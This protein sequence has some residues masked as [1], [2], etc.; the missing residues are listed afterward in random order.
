MTGVEAAGFVLGV[1]PLM[2]SAAEHYEDVFRPFNRYRKFAPELELYQQ[3]L[4]TQKTIFRNECH[5]LLATLTNRQTAKEMLREGKHPSWE[6][7]DL[8]ERF[9][10]Q[11]G[12]SGVACKNIIDLMRGKL[13]EIEEKTESFGL[14]L[15]H[16]FPVRLRTPQID[17]SKVTHETNM[18]SQLSS[19]RDKAWRSRIGKKLKFSLSESQLEKTLEDL[20]TLNQDFRTLAAQTNKLDDARQLPISSPNSPPRTDEA[21]KDCRLVRTAS[22]QLHQAL[23]RACKIHEKHIAHFRLESQHVT[24]EQPGLPIVRFNMAFTHCSSEAP[25]NL[26]PVWIAVDSTFDEGSPA[27]PQKTKSKSQQEAQNC[28]RELSGTLKREN[29]TSC[30]SPVKRIKARTVRFDTTASSNARSGMT[31]TTTSVRSAPISRHSHAERLLMQ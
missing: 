29:S 30:P 3:Q 10:K 14:V 15:Q 31:M 8:D 28:L 20:R 19:I 16:S 23:E 18:A 4:G 26:E 5:L 2:I 12:D 17:L 24:I 13:G 21:V 9:S 22:A 25:T 11:L 1:L 7:L 27:S 6:D